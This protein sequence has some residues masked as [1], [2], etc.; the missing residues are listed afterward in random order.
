MEVAVDRRLNRLAI[1]GLA[2]LLAACNY[3]ASGQDGG[4]AAARAWID[5]PLD[6]AEYL[7]GEAIPIR[8]H[9]AS[10]AGL[11]EVEVRINGETIDLADNLDPY[12]VIVT[13]EFDWTPPGAGEYLLEVIPTDSNDLVGA[14]AEKRFTVIEGAV[15]AGAVY[16]D[17]NA[18]GDAHDE[19]EGSLTGVSVV[20][21][22][23]GDKLSARTEGNGHFRFEAVPPGVCRM[24]FIKT[25]WRV[26]GTFPAGL[27]LPIHIHTM[28][29]HETWFSVFMTPDTTPTPSPTPTPTQTPTPTRMIVTVGPS[30]KP[31]ATPTPTKPAP[32]TQDPPIPT[33]ISP[34]DG[35]ML[36]CLDSIV[37]RWNPVTDAS[38]IDVYQVQLSV[39]HNNGASWSG[40]GSWDLDQFTQLDVSSQTDCGLLYLWKVRARDNAG[41]ASGWGM[42]TFA[43]GID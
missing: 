12:L 37:L 28:S 43:I 10:D 11:L 19:G 24:D 41:N 38:G 35:V 27:D 30:P 40:V 7:I 15:I 13:D 21:I 26:T 39:S 1:V 33:I 17:L 14:T 5:R 29:F 4:G 3:G 16:S 34:K 31:G 36:G 8:W 32:D 25:G 18:D 6:E 22:E 20:I 42:T 2:L 9:A 23:C